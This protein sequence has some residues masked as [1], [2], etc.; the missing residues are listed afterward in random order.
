MNVLVI[1][2]TVFGNTETIAKQIGIGMQSSAFIQVV[3]VND[4]TPA[5]IQ[6]A[7][8]LLLGSPTRGFRATDGMNNLVSELSSAVLEGKQI[9]T[10]DTRMDL[11]DI[12]SKM[13]RFIVKTGGFA[14]DKMAKEL[15]KKGIQL[16]KE[17]E[18]FLVTGEKGENMVPGEP[19]RAAGWGKS[20]L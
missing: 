14:A 5:Q 15:K 2:D 13:S 9:A 19:E 12:K 3:K 16:A 1:Y 10:F 17:P 8:F 6:E 4:V 18:G 11:T 7:D 20:L